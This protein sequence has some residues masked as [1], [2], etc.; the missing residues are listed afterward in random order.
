EDGTVYFRPRAAYGRVRPLVSQVTER[1]DVLA[2]LI[3]EGG[4]AVHGWTVLLHNTRLG[5]LHPD[6]V[7][8][9]AWGDPLLYSL[10]P[11]QP[12]VRRYAVTLC[13]DL[14]GHYD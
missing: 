1:Q 13:A 4:L 14:A 6:L 10:C 11:S 5:Q 3:A 7:V 8:R 2:E 9:N 12:E